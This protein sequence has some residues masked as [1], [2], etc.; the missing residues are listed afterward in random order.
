[1]QT[2]ETQNAINQSCFTANEGSKHSNN[3]GRFHYSMYLQ[4]PVL[5]NFG[6]KH[7]NFWPS[8]FYSSSLQKTK[9]VQ[10][11]FVLKCS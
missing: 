2:E 7:F 11:M 9:A 10:R 3:T 8:D 1:M 6:I 4:N 5:H